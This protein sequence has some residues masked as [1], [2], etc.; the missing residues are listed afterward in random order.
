MKPRD[1]L[2]DLAAHLGSMAADFKDHQDKLLSY[3]RQLES[4]VAE[5]T[6]ELAQEKAKLEI[7]VT[8]RTAEL[9]AANEALRDQAAQLS[10]RNQEITLFSKMNDF[11]Q[12]STTEAEAYSVISVTVT[13]LF[14]GD[15]GAVFVLN[16]SRT[17]LEAAATWGPLPP[18]K[19]VFPPD[20]CWAHRRGQVHL[21]IGHEQRCPHVTETGHM[22]V[23]LPLLAQGET[24]GVLYLTDGPVTNDKADEARMAEKCKQAKILADNIGLG[25]ANLKLRETMRNLSIRDP[26]T[27]LFNRRYMEEALAQ[28]QHRAK[29]NAAQLAIIMI[30]I[31]HFKKF[32]DEFGHDGGDAVLRELGA[33]FKRHVRG[34]DIACRYGGE[35]F[36]LILSPS[37]ADGARQRAEKIREG[38]GLLSVSQAD[39]T[40][41]AITL[42][43][44][45]AIFPDHAS[46]AAAMVKAADVALYQAKGGGRNRVA[47]FGE[48][49]EQITL[50]RSAEAQTR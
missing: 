4:M 49:A 32:N 30:D 18:A 35:E 50:Q 2:G 44:G 41:G 25:I 38:A 19:L 22:Y 36:S 20:E 37:T 31:D 45:V 14:P 27:G 15:S 46:N 10:R 26:L 1:E 17:T 40:L 7:S 9:K 34:S 29:R 21:A 48:K 24:L 39:R 23:C 12:T 8:L 6:A 43:L 5:R 47:M 28:E 16:A 33:F 11:L 13:Q 42:S 3:G